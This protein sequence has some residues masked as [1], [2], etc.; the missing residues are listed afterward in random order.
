VAVP[1]PEV[2]TGG[3]CCAPVSGTVI[4][5]GAARATA[6]DP[7]Q[8]SGINASNVRREIDISFASPGFIVTT[9]R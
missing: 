8:A 1:L 2:C 7:A 4:E 5:T 6:A 9:E 3:T